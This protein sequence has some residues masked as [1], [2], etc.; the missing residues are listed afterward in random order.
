MQRTAPTLFVFSGRPGVGKS[1]LARHLAAATNS[2]W[3]RIDTL[4]QALRDLCQIKV[5]GEGYRLAY[6]IAQDNLSLGNSVVADC[7]NPIAL[8]RNEWQAISSRA[9]ANHVDIEVICSDL[10]EHQA[11]IASRESEIPGLLLPDWEAVQAREYHSWQ[12]RAIQIDTAGASVLA[13]FNALASRLG[14]AHA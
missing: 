13:S 5:E 8:T 1:T 4:E 11:R 3:L 2:F 10:N 14:L 7:C 12:G 9:G 6:R